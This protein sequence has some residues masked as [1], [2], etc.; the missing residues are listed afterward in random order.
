MSMGNF[1]HSSGSSRRAAGVHASTGSATRWRPQAGLRSLR[2]DSWQ[3][4]LL[5]TA[6][7]VVMVGGRWP[8][9]VF[10]TRSRGKAAYTPTCRVDRARRMADAPPPNLGLRWWGPCA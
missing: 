8:T 2:G 6:K 3:R 10:R 1:G 5:A 9:A 4:L 7:R